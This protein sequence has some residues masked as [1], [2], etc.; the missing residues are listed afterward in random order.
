MTYGSLSRRQ[1]GLCSSSCVKRLSVFL[2]A[3]QIVLYGL[4][5]LPSR[6]PNQLLRMLGRLFVAFLLVAVVTCHGV[7]PTG[8]EFIRK[9][10]LNH[11]STR[12]ALRRYLLNPGVAP[13]SPPR[14]SPTMRQPAFATQASTR[15]TPFA[16]VGASSQPSR[17]RA[18]PS[19]GTPFDPTVGV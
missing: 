13:A 10:D 8:E 11:V 14:A 1:E 16:P 3:V 19:V 18:P 17:Q 2:L 12:L 9:R 6:V 4:H 5:L 7:L 15:G